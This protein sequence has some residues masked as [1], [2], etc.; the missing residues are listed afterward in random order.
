MVDKY[1]VF[2]YLIEVLTWKM[3]SVVDG[4]FGGRMKSMVVPGGKVHNTVVQFVAGF[5]L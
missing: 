1:E 5:D 2:T 4:P 3:A